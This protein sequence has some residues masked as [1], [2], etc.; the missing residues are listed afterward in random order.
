MK[1]NI[2]DMPRLTQTERNRVIG[3]ADMGAS[4]QQIARTFNCS[5]AAIRT[6]LNH[7]QQTG[8]AQDHSRSGR[9]RVLTPAEN[10]YIRTI[11]LC[12]HILLSFEHTHLWAQLLAWPVTLSAA[13]GGGEGKGVK[14]AIPTHYW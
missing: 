2:R 5:Q 11:Y 13:G 4:Q 10:S 14:L 9:P 7:Y 6:L 3:M 12:V 8:Q 1:K